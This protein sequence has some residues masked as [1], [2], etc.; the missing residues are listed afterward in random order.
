MTE[1]VARRTVI[2]INAITVPE[3]AGDE[4]AQRFAARAERWTT[5]K[6]LRVLSFSAPLMSG[7]SG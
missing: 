2:K 5:R 4:L 6:D 1:D 3:D 7:G